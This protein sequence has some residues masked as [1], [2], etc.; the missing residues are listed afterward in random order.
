MKI[1]NE[2]MERERKEVAEDFEIEC[3]LAEAFEKEQR[4]KKLRELEE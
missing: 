1:S 4:E 2:E 3:Q